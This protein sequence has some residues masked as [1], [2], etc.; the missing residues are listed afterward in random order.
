MRHLFLACVAAMTFAGA[1]AADGDTFE[2][3]GLTYTVVSEASHTC[4]VGVN[5][6][7][8]GAVVIPAKAVRGDVEY[9]VV[10]LGRDAFYANSDMTSVSIPA[11]VT[12]I[13]YQALSR[14]IGL[15][16]L[17]LPNSVTEVESRGVYACYYLEHLTLSTGL[18][19]I[20]REAFSGCPWLEEIVVPEGVVTIHEEA[21]NYCARATRL[22]LPSTVTS[23]GKMAFAGCGALEAVTLPGSLTRVDE[24]AFS[25]CP[26]IASVTVAKGAGKLMFGKNVFGDPT[27][28]HDPDVLSKIVDLTI[29]RE[30][31]CTTAAVGDRPFTRK[32]TI[33]TVT[34][35][36]EVAALPSG[37]FAESTGITL[38]RVEREAC[39]GATAD[40]FADGVYTAAVL[41]VPEASVGLYRSNG[42]WGRF[43]TVRGYEPAPERPERPWLL[44]GS[45]LELVEG[46]SATLTLEAAETDYTPEY[47]AEWSSSAPAVATVDAN[48]LV[49]AVAEGTAVISVRISATDAEPYTLECAVTVTPDNSGIDTIIAG[50]SAKAGTLYDLS[51]RRAGTDAPAGMY[52]LRRADGT[53]IKTIK[54]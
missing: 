13:R 37:C 1:R 30:F 23:I 20:N 53:S 12:A 48:G 6:E 29:N 45:A 9:T 46:T 15:T 18:R 54:R 5:C 21:F 38:V 7:A 28:A 22:T 31:D 16:E 52:I 24:E 50:D 39:P 10:A 11:T 2:W 19:E 25:Y 44:A 51:G 34:I 8:K 3:Q 42:V 17:T 4:E 41:E 36:R 47:T 40:C 33:R 43:A 27:Y 49:S 35:G 14:C 26:S 32:P